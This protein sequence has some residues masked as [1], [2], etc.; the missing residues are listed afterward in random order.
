MWISEEELEGEQTS[1]SL[2]PPVATSGDKGSAD[3]QQ[4]KN[5]QRAPEFI[6]F[7]PMAEPKKMHSV[8][9]QRNGA[10]YLTHTWLIDM[11][12]A[13]YEFKQNGNP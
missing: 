6:S 3:W 7:G 2:L 13:F 8:C 12:I 4:R 1:Y 5:L 10:Y 9:K 11:G